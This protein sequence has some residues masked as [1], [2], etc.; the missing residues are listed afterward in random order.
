REDGFRREDFED[1][2]NESDFIL[3]VDWR[4]LLADAMD[5]IVSQLHELGIEAYVNLDEEGE[6]GVFAANGE[7]VRIKYSINDEDN[8]D[9]VIASINPLISRKARYRKLRSSEGSDTWSYAI[10]N[11]EDWRGLELSA[12]R[13]VSLIFL[14]VGPASL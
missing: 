1:V 12:S 11:N 9:R 10:L 4:E 5:T 3:N 13:S 14:E 7:E 6:R 2:L 8:F